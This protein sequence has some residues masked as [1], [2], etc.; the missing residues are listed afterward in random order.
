MIFSIGADLWL[1][2]F[3]LRLEEPGWT[4]QARRAYE[5]LNARATGRMKNRASVSGWSQS[6]QEGEKKWNG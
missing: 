1:A 6:G 2:F 4:T 5:E 3:S